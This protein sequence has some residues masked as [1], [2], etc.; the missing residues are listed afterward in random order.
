MIILSEEIQKIIAKMLKEFW[1]KSEEIRFP[2]HFPEKKSF[3]RTL[4]SSFFR[5]RW[6][7]FERLKHFLELKW[8]IQESFRSFVDGKSSLI[9]QLAIY[10]AITQ[11][12]RS[13]AFQ[14]ENEFRWETLKFDFL[15]ALGA[16]KQFKTL[17]AG[18]MLDPHSQT[19]FGGPI[20]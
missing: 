11:N 4:K 5:V 16:S 20:L 10:S 6:K 8:T 9:A 18:L 7:L 2:W 14:L 19:A 12:Q 15:C 1:V 3:A 17:F 13:A